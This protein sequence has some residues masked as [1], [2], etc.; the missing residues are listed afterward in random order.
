MNLRELEPEIMQQSQE[1]YGINGND[2][3]QILKK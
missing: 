2:K 3:T 1:D